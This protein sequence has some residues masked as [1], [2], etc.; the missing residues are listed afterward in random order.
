[1]KSVIT[2]LLLVALCSLL[3]TDLWFV[4]SDLFPKRIQSLTEGTGFCIE[5]G[6]HLWTPPGSGEQSLLGPTA[7]PSSSCLMVKEFITIGGCGGYPGK[8][9]LQRRKLGKLHGQAPHIHGVGGGSL[10]NC[11]PLP[12]RAVVPH[13][14]LLC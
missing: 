13:L 7:L 12:D 5:G 9:P 4:P 3:L 6:E 8:L 14:S 2:P 10:Q 11:T 1:M